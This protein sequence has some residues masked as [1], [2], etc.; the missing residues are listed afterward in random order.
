MKRR[1]FLTAGAGIVLAGLAGQPLRAA[2]APRFS[3]FPEYRD[4]DPMVPVYVLPG[5][6]ALH[7]FFDTSP[8]S[9]SGRYVALFRMPYEDHSPQPGDAGDV[10][11]V[12]LESG[13]LR[14]IGRSRGWEVQVGANVQWGPTDEQLYFN[15]VDPATWQAFAVKMDPTTG[16][17]QRLD[18]TVFMVSPD[19]TQ[20]VSH[21]LV[22]SKRAQVGYGAVVPDHLATRNVGPV[23]DDGVFVTDTDTGRSRML[24]SLKTIYEQAEP[25]LRIS[26]PENYEYYC[27]QAKWNPQGSRILTTVQWSPLSGG[28]RRRAVITMNADGS[29][30][31]TAVTPEQWAGG[32]HHINWCPDGVRLSMNLNT[33]D[34][35]ELELVTFRFD[36]ADLRKVFEPGS[37]HP[38]FH[39]G[40]RYMVTDAYPGEQVAFGN[41]LVPIR[42]INTEKATCQDIIRINVS[43]VRGEFRVDAHPAWDRSG[44]YVTFN[45]WINDTRKVL[46][47][48]LSRLV[49]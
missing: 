9:P 17:R 38:S 49:G 14:T 32:G 46:V 37:G 24:V 7:R 45:G 25:S 12:D 29:Q 16:A 22:K 1:D 47:A 35:R 21:N 34:D 39:P 18:G 13:E 44:R 5:N 43:P 23:A 3:M 4:H 33:D 40:G 2:E 10:I 31:R 28:E 6:R 36:G 19:G 8:I 30:I 42:L 48:D 27:F 26:D 11:L 15:D 20:A 41:G